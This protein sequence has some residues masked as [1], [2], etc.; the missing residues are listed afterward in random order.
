MNDRDKFELEHQEDSTAL[1]GEQIESVLGKGS[2]GRLGCISGGR[3]FIVP[4]S[5]VYDGEAIFGC[6]F[7]GM[8]VR[9]MREHPSVCFEVEQVEKNGQ[10]RTV[11]VWGDYRELSAADAETALE[12]FKMRFDKELSRRYTTPR[13]GRHETPIFYKVVIAKKTGRI[14]R[15]LRRVAIA[16]MTRKKTT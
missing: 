13:G 4:I 10:I 12:L 3:V 11:L 8:K 7:D 5:Y 9:A 16:C 15:P 2:M 6:S 14:D 1:S